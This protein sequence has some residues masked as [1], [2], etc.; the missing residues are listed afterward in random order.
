MLNRWG[1]ALCLSVLLLGGW[2]D[3]GDPRPPLNEGQQAP[4]FAL[5]NGEGKEVALEGFLGKSRVVL[6]FLRG[7]F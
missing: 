6:L 4:R 2:P 1:L 7:F 3:T 5:Q